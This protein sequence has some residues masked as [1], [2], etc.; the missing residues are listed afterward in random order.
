MLLISLVIFAY[1]AICMSL[2]CR[3]MGYS[4]AIGLLTIVPYL[5][6][7]TFPALLWFMAFAKWPRWTDDWA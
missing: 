7:L 2:I 6:F 4:P 5:N 1:T 3:K